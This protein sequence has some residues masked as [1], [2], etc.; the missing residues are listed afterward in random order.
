MRFSKIPPQVVR[1]ILLTIVIVASYLVAR[2]FLTP[3]SFGKIGWY[4]AHALEEQASLQPVYAGMKP[5]AAVKEC[6]VCHADEYQKLIKHD[7]KTLSCETCHGP[8]LSH[9]D[10]PDVAQFKPVKLGYS[11]CIRCHEFNPSRP[12]WH[13]QV[14]LKSHYP[15][16]KCTECH[17]PHMP[18]EVP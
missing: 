16:Q 13:H 2:A 12:K 14:V 3:R 4:R 17:V 7:H 18:Q 15:D 5:S 8:C 1:I 9:A 11:M 10:Q 6:G